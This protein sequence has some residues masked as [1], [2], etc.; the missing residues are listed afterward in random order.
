[1]KTGFCLY[2]DFMASTVLLLP[3]LKHSSILLQVYRS[4]CVG[5]EESLK[6]V[7][8]ASQLLKRTSN[9][10]HMNES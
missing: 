3:K 1:M 7:F 9:D 6:I 2:F 8:L 10:D 5:P 4:V